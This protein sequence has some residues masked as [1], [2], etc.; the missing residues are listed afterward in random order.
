[1]NVQKCE[2]CGNEFPVSLLRYN[3]G[4]DGVWRYMCKPCRDEVKA[5]AASAE[6]R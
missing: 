5:N 1:M 3:K 2:G 4:G 6:V